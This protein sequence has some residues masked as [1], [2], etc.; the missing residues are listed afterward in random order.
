MKTARLLAASAAVCLGIGLGGCVTLFPK[1]KPVQL[2]SFGSGIGQ[3]TPTPSVVQT[4]LVGT[5][6][7]T[8]EFTRAA[9]REQILTSAGDANAY[10]SDAR[11]ISPAS[12]LFEEAANRAFE[13]ANPPIR[14]LQRGDNGAASLTLHVEVQTFE[15]DYG[16]GWRGDPTVVVRVR[17]LLTR[18]SDRGPPLEGHFESRKPVGE[19][20][21]GHIVQA[22]DAA[23]ADVLKQV[24]DWTTEHAG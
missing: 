9:D 17:T 12:V 19:S 23:T 22:Y 24:V 10:I 13:T 6:R 18:A 11:W 8:L 7:M 4:S 20:R 16:A 15:T 3:P 2:Y 5:L 14:L 1:T 21:V